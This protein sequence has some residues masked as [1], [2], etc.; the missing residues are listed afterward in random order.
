MAPPQ[1]HPHTNGT[2]PSSAQ[3]PNMQAPAA[4]PVQHMNGYGMHPAGGAPTQYA[5]AHQV[6]VPQPPAPREIIEIPDDDDEVQIVGGS[7]RNTPQTHQAAEPA[8]QHQGPW[9]G[10][11]MRR[12]N[13]LRAPGNQGVLL[14]DQDKAFLRQHDEAAQRMAKRA[15]AQKA[16]EVK[17]EKQRKA[18]EAEAARAELEKQAKEKKQQ[19][20]EARK[21]AEQRRRQMS[22]ASHTPA[23][24][25][26]GVMLPNMRPQPE[27]GGSTASQP[28]VQQ[29]RPEAPPQQN[30]APAPGRPKR[31]WTPTCA[32]VQAVAALRGGK[33][34]AAMGIVFQGAPN[35]TTAMDKLG[36]RSGLARMRVT[37]RP[38]DSAFRLEL[39]GALSNADDSWSYETLY[40]SFGF[41]N[42]DYQDG[43][44]L[45]RFTAIPN[46]QAASQE[47][48]EPFQ[49]T[50]GCIGFALRGCAAIDD[51]IKKYRLL[52]GSEQM[53]LM[54]LPNQ[55]FTVRV[56]GHVGTMGLPWPFETFQRHIAEQAAS[57]GLAL[58]Q[59]NEQ[60]Q[61]PSD[62]TRRADPEPAAQ[63]TPAAASRTP[64]DAGTKSPRADGS[65]CKLATSEPHA[66]NTQLL[67]GKTAV[68][69]NAPSSSAAA[70]SAEAAGKRKR[71]GESEEVQPVTKRSR[72][73][74]DASKAHGA[75][76]RKDDSGYSSFVH[77]PAGGD[78][79][80]ASNE[81]TTTFSAAES[82]QSTGTA[83]Q[84]NN[85][86]PG[87]DDDLVAQLKAALDGQA[88]GSDGQQTQSDADDGL[89]AM[90]QA[91]LEEAA[92]EPIHEQTQVPTDDD[93]EGQ[94][95]AF[96]EEGAEQAD[97]EQGQVNP[98]DTFTN[99]VDYDE[100][101]GS[102]E[103]DEQHDNDEANHRSPSPVAPD[104]DANDVNTACE[105]TKPASETSSHVEETPRATHSDARNSVDHTEIPDSDSESEDEDDS[106]DDDEDGEETAAAKKQYL[107]EIVALEAAIEESRQ[108]MAKTTNR[109]WSD[110]CKAKIEQS[111][112]EVA[113]KQ[114]ALAA[115][116]ATRSDE[117]TAAAKKRYLTGVAAL[118]A[119]IEER[120]KS[121]VNFDN[122]IFNNRC[123]LEIEQLQKE[124]ALKQAALAALSAS[125]SKDGEE[126]SL[127]LKTL[128]PRTLGLNTKIVNIGT[129]DIEI[130]VIGTRTSDIEKENS[131]F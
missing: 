81:P 2:M 13:R 119:A 86:K 3:V 69:E 127:R 131:G 111:E 42:A 36:L 98:N 32:A 61:G 30:P 40:R 76:E 73:D 93:L 77:S 115:L 16:E 37:F 95:Q 87:N 55:E 110:R 19:E 128:R 29:S 112:K 80:N 89:E 97:G 122:R 126:S 53:N 48:W 104:P 51:T 123:Q 12:L 101:F 94:S 52:M 84:P 91:A 129:R 23:G 71:S 83:L 67:S 102:S 50:S 44:A 82:N 108:S 70:P 9:E 15:K 121:M 5:P 79:Y 116:F 45:P 7:T 11:S 17:R 4:V 25:V 39:A 120:K 118:E 57:R 22:A 28:D 96:T 33:D 38:T 75:M 72:I 64:T 18:Q 34:N 56:M 99:D 63:P 66:Q 125:S 24:R 54:V 100:L 114:A 46:V 41:A 1:Q 68:A 78:I 43:W 8:A 58:A 31:T 21:A 107:A 14:N 10:F 124:I 109:I 117:E 6:N 74:H 103:D 60:Q 65:F 47:V 62:H 113:S 88:E 85:D 92:E 59:V 26:G 130:R 105:A 20:R 106:D 27:N 49:T 35:I 90:L